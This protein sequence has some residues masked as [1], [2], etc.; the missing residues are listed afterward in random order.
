MVQPILRYVVHE[1]GQR[2]I[3]EYLYNLESMEWCWV[4]CAYEDDEEWMI[5]DFVCP[6]CGEVVD[7]EED[8]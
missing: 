5:G 6:G 4:W 1:C 7:M 8:T 3:G 2:L